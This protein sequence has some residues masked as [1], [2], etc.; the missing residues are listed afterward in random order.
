[1]VYRE[2]AFVI[3]MYEHKC[4]HRHLR[5]KSEVNYTNKKTSQSEKKRERDHLHNGLAVREL[6][7]AEELVSPGGTVASD[8]RTAGRTLL[9]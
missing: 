8:T 5:K 9:E 1:M 3:E 2:V 4:L 7:S 6:T